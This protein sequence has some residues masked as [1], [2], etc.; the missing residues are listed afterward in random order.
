M[1]VYYFGSFC[2]DAT[3]HCLQ[4]NGQPLNLAPKLLDI[5]TLL[6]ENNNRLVTKEEIMLKIWPDQF[7]E[8]SNLTVS[9]SKIRKVL[10]EDRR[11]HKFILTFSRRGYRF[12]ATVRRAQE[13]GL[14]SIAVL[15]FDNK[16]DDQ[17][18]E[19][20]AD[21][22]TES[23][24]YNL[25]NL[26][27]LRVVPFSA[28]SR[29]KG[30][31]VEPSRIA[32]RLSVSAVLVGRINVVGDN[33]TNSIELL[34]VR[35][36]ELLWCRRYERKTADFLSAQSYFAAEITEELKHIVLGKAMEG[37]PGL[38]IRGNDAHQLYL[39]GRFHWNKRTEEDLEKSIHYFNKAINVDP[40]HAM[41]Y[42]GLSDA[43]NVLG[44]H[45]ML[46]PALAFGRAKKAAESALEIDDS[47][48]EAH[49]SLGYTKLYYDW[50]LSG[51]EKC[52]KRALQLDSNCAKAHQFYANHL[53]VANSFDEAI[54][55]LNRALELDPLSLIVQASLGY[56]HYYARQYD[57]SIEQFRK[58]I[59]LDRHFEIAHVWL[60]CG[61]QQ[62]GL[63]EEA[64]RE[65]EQAAKLSGSQ[66]GNLAALATTYALSGNRDEAIKIVRTLN[67]VSKEKYVSPCYIAYI[68]AALGELN[69]AVVWLEKAYEVRAHQL[70]GLRTDPNLDALRGDPRFS[71]LLSRVSLG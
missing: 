60:A 26:P 71:D 2:L 40:D 12:I 9:M 23:L 63:W 55:E 62:K 20:M 46:H 56:C 54:T 52:F 21:A 34:D 22:L 65:Y 17:N 5:L 37:S 14:D 28:V 16:S 1:P 59:D 41:S 39:R 48:A 53:A 51:A 38:V 4:R 66:I 24:I 45:C 67:G 29:C 57:Q 35:C 47:L 30:K 10:G 32:K 27:G 36:K 8:D 18:T 19:H 49:A 31:K 64:I 33:I 25:S 42:V 6:V 70:L 58:A 15:P 43:Y 13:G 11:R 44:F 61:Y 7:V 69:S 3:E 68:Y 50:N